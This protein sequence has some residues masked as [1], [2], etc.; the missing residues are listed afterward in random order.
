MPRSSEYV[1][2]Y[3]IACNRERE[4]VAK[5]LEGFGFRQQKSVFEC[6]L[7]RSRKERLLKRLVDLRL[8]TG[9]VLVYPV[10]PNGKARRVGIEASQE[11]QIDKGYS[12]V[13]GL[14]ESAA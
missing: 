3:D 7:T 5:T 2:A 9:F 4:R 1:V 13:V 14:E 6:R 10:A 11:A 8:A 12:Y